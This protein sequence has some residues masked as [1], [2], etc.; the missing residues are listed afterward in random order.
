[1]YVLYLQSI[2]YYVLFYKCVKYQNERNIYNKKSLYSEIIVKKVRQVLF[3][4]NVLLY[5]LLK[6]IAL[7]ILMLW[8][9]LNDILTSKFLRVK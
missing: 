3:R 5:D 6:T 1:L 4:V 8:R 9:S 2:Y 7:E